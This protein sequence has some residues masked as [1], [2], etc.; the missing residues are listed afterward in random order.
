MLILDIGRLLEYA[1]SRVASDIQIAILVFKWVENLR[2]T[3]ELFEDEIVMALSLNSIGE[4][5]NS[6]TEPAADLSFLVTYRQFFSMKSSI[7][8]GIDTF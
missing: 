4:K 5:E 8:K 6:A 3:T 1:P 7:F 2:T